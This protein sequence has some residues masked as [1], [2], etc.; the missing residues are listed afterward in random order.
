[1]H[2]VNRLTG[3]K[4]EKCIE[5]AKEAI[6]TNHAVVIG[7]Q[8]TGEAGVK[9]R[10]ELQYNGQ[11]NGNLGNGY[12]NDGYDTDDEEVVDFDQVSYYRLKESIAD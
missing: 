11:A 12:Q 1:M 6:R 3:M 2:T 9:H 8:M 10:Q 5:L 4:V 7:L